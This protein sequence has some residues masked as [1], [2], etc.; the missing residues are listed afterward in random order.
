MTSQI[1]VDDYVAHNRRELREILRQPRELSTAR[2]GDLLIEEGTVTREQVNEALEQQRGGHHEKLGRLLLARGLVTEEQV[3]RALG[4]RLNVPFV[5]LG[6][7]DIEPRALHLVDADFARTHGVVPLMLNG[8]QLVVAL[9]RVGDPELMDLL[10]FLSGHPIQVVSASPPD[11]DYAISQAYDSF[12]DASLAREVERITGSDR[13]ESHTGGRHEPEREQAIARQQPVVKL[14][15]NLIVDAIRRRA[16]DIHIRP[17][18]RDAEVIFRIDGSLVP[19]RTF[20]KS[21]LPAIVSRIKILGSMD[22]SEHRLPQDG[23]A[24]MRNRGRVIDLRLSVIPAIYGESLVIRILDVSQGLKSLNEIGFT[25]TDEE[26]FRNL[27]RHNQGLLLVTGPTGSGKSTT[28][29]AALQEVRKHDVNIITVEDPVEY[30]LDGINQIQV[31]P[32]IGYTFARALRH[33]LRHD[34]DVVMVGEIR[35][36]ETAK[37]AVESAL[38][39]HLVLS[40]LHTNSAATSITRLLE[41]GVDAYLTRATVMAVLAQRLVRLNCPH[42]MQEETVTAAVREELGLAEHEVFYQG[43]GC[44]QCFETGF[45][46]RHAV[47][48]LLRVT[49]AMR[50]R[51][52][53]NA[54]AMELERQAG[55]DG[56]VPL[57][58]NALALAREGQTSIAEVYR[59][60]LV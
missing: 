17:R 15:Q 7:F 48:E 41:I 57:T 33:I 26:N 44:D 8:E 60:R 36:V 13:E 23:Q 39:G 6:Q 38:T 25:P 54:D 59:V 24:R 40:T 28:L 5:R 1:D 27:L 43:V 35:D 3:N 46:G 53:P 11:I 55:A 14:V 50:E 29:Y 47:Y 2:I 22:I 58:D 31:A 19:V 30:H 32:Q 51:I 4:R 34:P 16:S 52:H 21:V 18:E 49:P 45:R 56:M 20:T 10:H 9:D 37:M 12:N 42:C